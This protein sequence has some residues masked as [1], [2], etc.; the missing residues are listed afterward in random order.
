V[1]DQKHLIDVE[2]PAEPGTARAINGDCVLVVGHRPPE[3]AQIRAVR[4]STGLAEELED[5]L[6]A[7][8]LLCDGDRSGDAPDG[9]G[10]DDLEQRARIAADERGKYPLNAVERV[11]RSSG[12][13]V[14]P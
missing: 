14:R 5:A 10:I 9:V 4:E 8:V 12:A 13:I 7:A 2:G 6:T 11:Y 3:L 1:S